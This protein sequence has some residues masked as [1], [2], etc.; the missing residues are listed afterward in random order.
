MAGRPATVLARTEGVNITVPA[1]VSLGSAFTG[2]VLNGSLGTVTVED[3]RG[4]VN[5]NT[6]VTT[7]TATAFVTGAGGAGRTIANGQVSYWSGQAVRSTGGGTLVP[8]QPTSAQAVPLD[9]ARVAFSKTAGNGNNTVSW[10]PTLRIAVPSGIV[11]GTYRG[12]ITHSV[13]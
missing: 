6:W 7:V 13:A 5:P 11:A 9:A 12:T 3:F 8:G 10:A 1:S 2:G 4:P